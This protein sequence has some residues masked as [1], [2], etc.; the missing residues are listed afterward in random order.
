MKEDNYE[1]ELLEAEDGILDAARAPNDR[2]A[3][4]LKEAA[5]QTYNKDKR[6]NIRISSRDLSALQKKANRYGMPYQTLVSSV[7]HRYV[8]GDLTEV[9]S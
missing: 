5:Q 6:I 8:T 2:E 7:L 4:R 3:E 9:D 1:K